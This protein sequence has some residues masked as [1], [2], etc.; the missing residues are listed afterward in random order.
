MLTGVLPFHDDT[1]AVM[2]QHITKPAQPPSSMI[3]AV[4]KELDAVVLKMLK[5]EPEGRDQS[6]AELI[7]A[8]SA[9]K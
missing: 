9:L 8:L 1:G 3:P 5:R 7:A 4:G 6:T 2:A